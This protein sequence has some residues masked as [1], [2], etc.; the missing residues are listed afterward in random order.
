MLTTLQK[1]KRLE[2]LEKENKA[3][4]KKVMHYERI[5]G[6]CTWEKINAE[7]V[8]LE[9][10][11]KTLRNGLNAWLMCW[12]WQLDPVS[13]RDMQEILKKEV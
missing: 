2:E 4:L 8:R 6:Y 1:L 11:N 10:E 3:L 13:I 5:E 9:Q 7:Y 12:D